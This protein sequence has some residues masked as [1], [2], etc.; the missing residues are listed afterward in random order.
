MPNL[1][2]YRNSLPYLLAGFSVFAYCCVRAI[3][4]DITTDESYTVMYYA[5]DTWNEVLTNIQKPSANNH[6]LNSILVKLSSYLFGFKVFAIRIPSLCALILYITFSYKLS[7]LIV[8]RK[9]L[10]FL[11][12]CILISNPY[13]LEMFSL[14]RGYGLS[15]AFLVTS[16]YY[17]L[18]Y[19][20]NS[21]KT[22]NL[23]LA[24]FL[25]LLAV[26]SSFIIINVWLAFAG[27]LFIFQVFVVKTGLFKTLGIYLAFSII[28]T[29]IIWEP[30]RV[31]IAHN[32]FYYGGVLGIVFDSIYDL[33]MCLDYDN[34][35]GSNYFAFMPGIFFSIFFISIFS[36]FNSVRYKYINNN[37]HINL[38]AITII[39]FIV[40]ASIGTQFTLL[41]TPVAK[42]RTALFLFPLMLLN[43]MALVSC[44][45]QA[46][47]T[48]AKSNL[49]IVQIFSGLCLIFIFHDISSWQITHSPYWRYNAEN[50]KIIRFIQSSASKLGY[51]Q[52]QF[53]SASTS[54]LER[55]LPYYAKYYSEFKFFKYQILP[56]ID[57]KPL[58]Y[59]LYDDSDKQIDSLKQ[60]LTPIQSFS[61][62][63][64][65]VYI[66]SSALPTLK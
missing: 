31:N 14:A 22:V 8:Q 24:L 49:I 21:N 41:G 53:Q 23:V 17:L 59:I 58:Y 57:N 51:R 66:D 44:Y 30:V 26:Y 42:A 12:F 64:I 11:S 37:M 56:N 50:K 62:S 54:R 43:L 38:F 29:L 46:D 15:L 2:L 40:L 39:L 27:F 19:L 33:F 9:T 45:F 7:K 10:V 4:L 34:V 60:V 13:L 52:N 20:H 3:L 61:I 16:I 36:I 1:F 55:V 63:H 28:L 48:K 35:M 65:T 25:L 18:K 5:S 47:V 6:I 32:E